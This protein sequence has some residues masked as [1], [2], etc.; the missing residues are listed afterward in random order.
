MDTDNLDEEDRPDTKDIRIALRLNI[1]LCQAKMLD[2]LNQHKTCSKVCK[3]G[4]T[5]SRCLLYPQ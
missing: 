1:S 5:C 3:Y 4:D 2:F